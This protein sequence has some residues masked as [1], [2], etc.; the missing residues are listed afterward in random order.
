MKKIKSENKKINATKKKKKGRK[1]LT[2]TNSG[3]LFVLNLAEVFNEAGN[4]TVRGW[5]QN[6][7]N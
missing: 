2:T 4:K 3:F 6:C 7:T 1:N 5:E